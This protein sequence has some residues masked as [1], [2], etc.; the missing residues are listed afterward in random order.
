M[1]ALCICHSILST[2]ETKGIC[3]KIDGVKWIKAWCWSEKQQQH[4]QSF[5][6]WVN[7][8]KRQLE[9]EQRGHRLIAGK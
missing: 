8:K 7:K 1:V 9:L 4:V 2:E 3:Q 6:G 5:H